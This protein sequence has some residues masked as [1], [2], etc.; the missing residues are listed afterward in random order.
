MLFKIG[1]SQFKINFEKLFLLIFSFDLHIAKWISLFCI[2]ILESI[3]SLPS[4]VI[5]GTNISCINSISSLFSMTI[6]ND[7]FILKEYIIFIPLFINPYLHLSFSIEDIFP[8]KSEFSKFKLILL[9]I[10][11]LLQFCSKANFLLYIFCSKIS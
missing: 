7:K 6:L 2:S 11:S 9:K 8:S 4:L 1:N 3:F 5:K 10:F